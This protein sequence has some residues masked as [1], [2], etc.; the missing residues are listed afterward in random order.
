MKAPTSK[1][2]GPRRRTRDQYRFFIVGQYC[3]CEDPVNNASLWFMNI[4]SQQQQP[5]VGVLLKIVLIRLGD[6]FVVD[7]CLMIFIWIGHTKSSVILQSSGLMICP[8]TF[9][10]QSCIISCWEGVFARKVCSASF[11]KTFPES[12]HHAA[13]HADSGSA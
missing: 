5:S 2:I 12:F 6:L 7:I 10:P 11:G 1:P 8:L 4:S 13:R 3:L 9:S